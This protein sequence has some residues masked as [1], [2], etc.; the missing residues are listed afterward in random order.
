MKNTLEEIN[1]RVGDTEECLSNLEYTVMEINSA[2]IRLTTLDRRLDARG[3][4]SHL[5]AT[6]QQ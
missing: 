4:L 1:R 3:I 2:K 5:T 6:D